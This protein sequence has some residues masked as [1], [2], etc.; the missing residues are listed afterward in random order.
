MMFLLCKI[1][2]WHRPLNQ[3]TIRTKVLVSLLSHFIFKLF[4]VNFLIEFAFEFMVLCGLC[5]QWLN[6]PNF[7]HHI[8]LQQTA[9]LTLHTINS[10][11]IWRRHTFQLDNDRQVISDRICWV[12]NEHRIYKSQAF[13]LLILL[14]L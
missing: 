11:H 8:T 13:N 6:K 9:T 12:Q 10:L 5:Q 1:N 3:K 2:S 4:V 14:W 7:G